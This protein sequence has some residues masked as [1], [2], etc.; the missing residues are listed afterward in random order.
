[1]PNCPIH[2][3]EMRLFNGR[4]GPVY[5][6]NTFLGKGAPGSNRN[7]YCAVSIPAPAAVAP[8]AAPQPVAASPGP[9]LETQAVQA[10]L[11]LQAAIAAVQG[12]ATLYSGSGVGP[13]EVVQAARI[14]YHLVLKPAFL[15]DVPQPIPS[16]PLRNAP[17]PSEDTAAN[18]LIDSYAAG[19]T[20]TEF[21]P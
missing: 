17:P 11:R 12:A 10:P 7:G 13:H 6:C 21:Y 18:N 14:I 15:A 2:G 3:T 5:T 8:Q 16:V 1:M 4:S 20:E 19:Q 9:A